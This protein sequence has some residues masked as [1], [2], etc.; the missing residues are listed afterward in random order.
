V[1]IDVAAEGDADLLRGWVQRV[2]PQSA[3]VL[4]LIGDRWLD[5]QS[6]YRRIDDPNDIVRFEIELALSNSI[7]LI[8]VMVDGVVFPTA[9]E[10]PHS[11]RGLLEFKGYPVSNANWDRELNAISSAVS[12]V[13][14]THAP[15]LR[16]GVDAW[17]QWRSENPTIRPNLKRLSQ[18][19]KLLTGANLSNSDLEGTDFEQSDLSNANLSNSNLDSARFR[20]AVLTNA[21]LDAASLR[22][23]DLSRATL[24]GADLSGADLRH[25]NLNEAE[26]TNTKL[27]RCRVFGV[28]VWNA[29]LSGALQDNL[30]LDADGLS[31]L[32]TDSIEMAIVLHLLLASGG[33][34]QMI[35]TLTSK[36]V[37]ILGRFT[38]KRKAIL[39]AVRSEL[40]RYNYLPILF[41]FEKPSQRDLA[42]TLATVAHM[43]RFVIAEIT[44]AK[45]VPQELMMIVPSLPSVPVQPLL[46]ASEQEYVVFQEVL[47]YPWVLKPFLYEDEAGLRAGFANN[48]IEPVEAKAREL[49]MGKSA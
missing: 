29:H 40:R 31:E 32:T 11:I 48:V 6:G 18:H 44:D 8:P 4:V 25:A 35:D 3:V 23:A 46:H 15:I 34:R 33:I 9:A 22:Y 16:R 45:S 20:S 2:V 43:A 37:L 13:A 49:T 27:Y 28:S 24:T 12:S 47:R 39:D 41:D 5:S 36:V 19:G 26:L 21:R 30:R 42:E 38:P 1:V 10:L 7:P 14:R 17:N